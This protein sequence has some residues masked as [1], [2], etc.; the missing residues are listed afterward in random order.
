MKKTIGFLLVGVLFI[1]SNCSE[2]DMVNHSVQKGVIRA[3]LEQKSSI[4]R[5]AIGEGNALSWASG[6]AFN[7]YNSEGISS[8][9]TLKAGDEGKTTAAFEGEFVSGN[10][11]GALYPANIEQ[12]LSSQGILTLTL[13]KDITYMENQV[14][15][16]MWASFNSVLDEVSFK[17]LGA[18][19]KVN[20]NDIPEGYTKMKVT[21]IPSIAGEFT[22]D[23][24]K[25]LTVNGGL[26]PSNPSEEGS[27]VVDFSNA[28][29]SDDQH[30]LWFYL[31]IPT[32][33]YQSISITLLGANK[34]DMLLDN[35][36]DIVIKRKT[37]YYTSL[38]GRIIEA[39]T[40]SEFNQQVENEPTNSS[41]QTQ[42]YSIVGQI[43]TSKGGTNEPMN[44]PAVSDTS[45]DV[46]FIFNS[47]PVTTPEK[48]LTI[49]QNTNPEAVAD[50]LVIAVP[51]SNTEKL[52][53]LV[54]ETPG[55]TVTAKEG[56]YGTVTATTSANTFIVSK[57]VEIDHLIVKAGNVVVEGYVKKI[58][59][60]ADNKENFYVMLK[61]GGSVEEM[62]DNIIL[63][64]PT[65]YDETQSYYNIKSPEEL[66]GF[67]YL[68]YTGTT[69][70]GKTIRLNND[71]DMSGYE[72][73]VPGMLRNTE[74]FHYFKGTLDGK[75]FSIKNLQMN[76]VPSEQ[77][78]PNTKGIVM[79]GLIPAAQLAVIQNLTMEGGQLTIQN[80]TSDTDIFYS[81]VLV[82]ISEGSSIINCH[83]VNNGILLEPMGYA[84][85]LIGR[86]NDYSSVS[87]H[88][89]GCS[90]SGTVMSTYNANVSATIC[91]GG[92]AGG[93]W[94]ESSY[95]VGCYNT[96][97]VTGSSVQYGFAGGIAA[98]F[99]GY[100][101]M[102]GCFNSGSVSGCQYNGELVGQASYS[103]YYNYSA[104]TGT[105][106][107]G[108]DF[109]GNVTDVY[110]SSYSDAYL[111]LNTGILAYNKI[112]AVPCEYRFVEGYTPS[113]EEFDGTGSTIVTDTSWYDENASTYL[114][115]SREDLVGFLELLYGGITFESKTIQL[116]HNID[117]YDYVLD[118]P[119]MDR[120]DTE[121]CH[122]FRGV[123]DGKGYSIKNLKMN[124][125]PNGN[126]NSQLLIGFI[127]ASENATFKDLT[128][129]YGY[130][131]SLGTDNVA[132]YYVG[133]LVGYARGTNFINCH[134]KQCHVTHAGHYAVGG[135]VGWTYNACSFIA[136]SNSATVSV[137]STTTQ[138]VFIGGIANGW[139]QN[140]NMVACY[141]L[142]T[143]KSNN[144]LGFA[145]GISG[146]FAGKNQMYGCFNLGSVMD[147][148][149]M[150]ALI[151]YGS[152][153]NT[154]LYN[155]CYSNSI[156][157][158]GLDWGIIAED[159]SRLSYADA[160]IVL[161]TGI[162]LYNQTATIPCEYRFG[163]GNVPVLEK[164]GTSGSGIG[165]PGLDEGGIF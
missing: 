96:G 148:E 84:G 79:V 113:L 62:D 116:G 19:L 101:Y 73:D 146:D 51:T 121:N 93:G 10:W 161:N 43:D 26:K 49:E 120:K 16:P 156:N 154:L 87:T 70:E 100:N 106:Y 57:D 48:P 142:G 94:G 88:L 86:I 133:A 34:T 82:G 115:D 99:A 97:E 128:L 110:Q 81:G 78:D 151:G 24:T 39:S 2:E 98:D 1:L 17:H 140:M 90:N 76:Y 91:I 58:T 119:G 155:S 4:S 144:L 72:L 64:D 112:G 105:T 123:F 103:G 47:T 111:T 85:G 41:S 27:V 32:G 136:C 117:M 8:E 13:P 25:E 163:A 83:N 138:N 18:M 127:P 125:D 53:N 35:W 52:E 157:Y 15:V 160:V 102:Y 42:T 66:V 139:G 141:N 7:V 149:N 61:E 9:L 147:T 152:L 158:Y 95:I 134:N 126:S 92:I 130:I 6:D 75:G 69:F 50:E 55:M 20:V 122:Y 63:N 135:L 71:I 44:V 165:T 38:S 129:E 21:S 114:L 40:T 11:V 143:I 89:V 164:V 23:I 30:D 68:L 104:F 162:E 14:K 46:S 22:F 29:F 108:Q 109:S 59:R 5:M 77:N 80:T 36:K 74:S 60:H 131:N 159:V 12:N 65:W 153:N 31:P 145:G 67:L 132:S 107:V 37:V 124:F 150:G 45:S 137:T 3:T 118:K 33:N 54:V 28:A 56:S